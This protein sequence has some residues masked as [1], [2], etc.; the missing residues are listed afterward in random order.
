[1]IFSFMD[2][3]QGRVL[4]A[5]VTDNGIS[6]KKSKLYNFKIQTELEDS[7]DL[8]SRY[9]AGYRIGDTRKFVV[10]D[11]KAQEIPTATAEVAAAN[12]QDAVPAPGNS[13]P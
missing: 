8:F 7:M 3:F 4:Q 11:I 1:M 9:M 10:F 13:K 6:I 5:H 12:I 2:S